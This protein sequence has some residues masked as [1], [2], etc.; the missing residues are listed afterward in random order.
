MQQSQV[1]MCSNTKSHRDITASS[2]PRGNIFKM[3]NDNRNLIG[4]T[5]LENDQRLHCLCLILHSMHD[6]KYGAPSHLELKNEAHDTPLKCT[7]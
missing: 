7:Q 5:L 1:Y 4:Q 3:V 2:S 6:I